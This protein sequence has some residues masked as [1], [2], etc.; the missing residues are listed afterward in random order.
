MRSDRLFCFSSICKFGSFK[1]P[2][3]MITS[4]PELYFRFRRLILL[5]QTKKRFLWIMAAAQAAENDGDKWHLT[6]YLQW[7]IHTSIPT[8][9]H[10]QRNTDFKDTLPWNISQ[11]IIKTISI[12]TRIVISYAMKQGIPFWVSWKVNG[13]WDNN[14]VRISHWRENHCR[15]NTRVRKKK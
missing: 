9:T 3:T 14:M 12:S 15:I 5:V 7:G 6:W 2:F 8:W 11:M 10:S 13:N 1:N 4:L